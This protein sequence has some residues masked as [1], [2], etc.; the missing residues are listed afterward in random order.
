MGPNARQ[1]LL[2]RLDGLHASF[3]EAEERYDEA[4][5]KVKKLQKKRSASA[6]AEAE[7]AEAG[8]VLSGVR[9]EIRKAW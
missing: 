7:L 8:R 3:E 2:E 1:E 5:F 4:E 9:S 6:E